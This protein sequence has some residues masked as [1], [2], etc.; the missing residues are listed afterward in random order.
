LRQKSF[1]LGM[2]LFILAISYLFAKIG[3]PYLVGIG[4]QEGLAIVITMIIGL[5][6]S[7]AFL[8]FLLLRHGK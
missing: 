5:G 7:G 6:L 2:L 4:V 8:W 1:E 3:I